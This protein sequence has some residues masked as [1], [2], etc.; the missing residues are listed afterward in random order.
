MPGMFMSKFSGWTLEE[1]PMVVVP[2]DTAIEK[3]RLAATHFGC[4]VPKELLLLYM[5]KFLGGRS[6]R[7]ER[8]S[9]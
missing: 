8:V 2:I 6:T 3:C 5:S 4:I 7:N 9:L 1:R